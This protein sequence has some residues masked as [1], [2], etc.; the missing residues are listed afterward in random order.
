M[1]SMEAMDS[2][3]DLRWVVPVSVVGGLTL[4]T[5]I[6]KLG[7]W[8]SGV[9][10]DREGFRAFMEEV[11]EDIKEILRRLPSTPAPITS[12]S[13]LRL[14]D[15]GETLAE[16]MNATAWATRE[17]P[18]VGRTG[19]EEPFQLDSLAEIYVRDKLDGEMDVLMAKC[20]YEHGTDKEGLR[21]VLRVVLRDEL[22]RLTDQTLPD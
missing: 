20:A 18:N 3:I 9:N 4:I 19:D 22:L 1:R 16:C 21:N 11:R 6:F 7:G 13:P 2:G 17:A 14:T 5:F 10:S 15:F 12:S 8:Y